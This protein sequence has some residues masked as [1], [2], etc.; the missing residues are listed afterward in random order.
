MER[1][2]V[3]SAGLRESDFSGLPDLRS[4]SGP[5]D[6]SASI[7]FPKTN[8]VVPS[9]SNK[10]HGCI[11]IST[12]ADLRDGPVFHVRP[13]FMSQHMEYRLVQVSYVE[14]FPAFHA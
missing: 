5:F 9:A 12:N 3:P 7:A 6:A 4:V 14:E 1:R 8:K 2:V 10:A 11:A 13:V